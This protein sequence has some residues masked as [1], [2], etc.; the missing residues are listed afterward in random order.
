MWPEP[1]E[2]YCYRAQGQ[3]ITDDVE[4]F[5]FLGDGKDQHDTVVQA[6]DT[7]LMRAILA[8]QGIHTIGAASSTPI[9]MSARPE[10]LPT[11]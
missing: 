2:H 7:E 5:L 8:C 9:T 3:H 11:A 6:L 4:P 1:Q 10:G